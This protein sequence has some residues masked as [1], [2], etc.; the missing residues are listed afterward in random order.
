MSA[1]RSHISATLTMRNKTRSGAWRK[2]LPGCARRGAREGYETPER[3]SGLTSL[4]VKRTSLPM[5]TA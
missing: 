4:R 2:G 3:T 1:K 5:R